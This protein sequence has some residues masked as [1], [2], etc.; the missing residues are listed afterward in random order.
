M[1]QALGTGSP[2]AHAQDL[3]TLVRRLLDT[4]AFTGDAIAAALRCVRKESR[5][6]LR[7]AGEIAGAVSKYLSALAGR[8]PA[9]VRARFAARLCAHVT[10]AVSL[11]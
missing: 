1:R 10:S 8:W 9:E 4:P 7:A 5:W 2:V 11:S 6:R 3:V